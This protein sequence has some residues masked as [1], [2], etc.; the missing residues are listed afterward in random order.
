MEVLQKEVDSG[1]QE[2]REKPLTAAAEAVVGRS[3]TGQQ[4][5]AMEHMLT[6]PPVL[7]GTHL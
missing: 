6:G 3:P 2:V 4:A 5:L 1:C 7:S